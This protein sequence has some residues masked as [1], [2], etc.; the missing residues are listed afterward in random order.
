MSAAGTEPTAVAE[1]AAGYSGV[2]KAETAAHTEAE[3]AAFLM[4]TESPG[5]A[6]IRED[7]AQTPQETE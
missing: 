1:E 6:F 2:P 4:E 7:A 3:E 5:Y